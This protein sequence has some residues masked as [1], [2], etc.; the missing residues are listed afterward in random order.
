[1]SR[2]V[3][4]FLGLSL[5]G[6]TSAH[7]ECKLEKI[8]EF[9]VTMIDNKAVADAE[10][11]GTKVRFI[12]DSGAFFSTIS[13]ALAK[14]LK[15][16]TTDAPPE[17]RITGVGGEVRAQVTRVS[18]FKLAGVKIPQAAF[19]V[20]DADFGHAG[21][22]G[23]DVLGFADVEYDLPHG[24]VR[25]MRS[26]DCADVNLAYWAAERP[27][28][29]MP[30]D[31]VNTDQPHTVGTVVLNTAKLRAMFDTGA[32]ST[33]V[34]LDGARRAG[35]TPSSPGVVEAGASTGLGSKVLQSW[36]APFDLID[37]GGEQIKRVKLRM[38]S[39][40]LSDADMLIGADFF[41]SHRVYVANGL[42]RLYFTYEGG[43]V[44]NIKPS[45]AMRPDGTR[46]A[47]ADSGSEPKTADEFARRGAAL[48]AKGDMAKAMADLNRAVEMAPGE[49]R[50]VLQRGELHQRMDKDELALADFNQAVKLA[51]GDGEARVTRAAALLNAGE[52][53]QA[54]ADLKAADAALPANADLRL[55]L[56]WLYTRAGDPV[57]AITNYD[58]WFRTHGDDPSRG[59]AFNGRCWARAVLGR[60]LDKALKDCNAALKVEPGSPDILDSRALVLLKSGDLQGA[61]ADYSA[62]IAKQ[63]RN[64]WA[65][66]ARGI[67]HQRL[68]DTARAEADHKAALAIA[69][70]ITRYAARLGLVESGAPAAAATP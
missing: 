61:V 63:P 19:L 5:F 64:A 8:V 2:I 27:V 35:V 60:D 3:S 9:P 55:S 6:A 15:L 20:T 29:I 68:G 40:E 14:D 13:R 34:T 7:A 58:Q 12:L 52:D 59:S 65:L 67:A 47:V 11:N 37:I 30:I 41:L 42:R 57:T 33:V 51:P 1:M 26:R 36:L 53:A 21:L 4:I 32:Y 45:G 38:S 44:F 18:Q 39:L 62:V 54:L 17:F 43:P 66:Y 10:I 16:V 50:Y 23:Q 56:G 25:L 49:A 24:M 46:V 31:R 69:P 22:I 70:K 28:T 48:I